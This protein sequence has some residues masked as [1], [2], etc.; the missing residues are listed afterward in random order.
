MFLIGI[1]LL[2]VKVQLLDRANDHVDSQAK[3][4]LLRTM[5]VIVSAS[6]YADKEMLLARY[7]IL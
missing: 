5:A 6:F 4:S 2:I 3:D 7:L 1:L